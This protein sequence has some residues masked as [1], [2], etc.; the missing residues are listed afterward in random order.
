VN[1]PAIYPYLNQGSMNTVVNS[2]VWDNEEF[3]R[4]GKKIGYISICDVDN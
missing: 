1:F 3:Y 4:D 2:G